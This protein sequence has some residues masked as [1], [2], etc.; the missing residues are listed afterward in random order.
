MTDERDNRSDS[1]GCAEASGSLERLEQLESV[2]D[3]VAD[4]IFVKD[5]EHR[6]VFVNQAFA[7]STGY[8][9]DEMVGK[10]DADL[11]PPEETTIF[12]A[13]DDEVLRN[14]VARD[15][16]LYFT[17]A[18][19]TK[20]LVHT[21]KSRVTLT[22]GQRFVVG[23]MHD[24][25][26]QRSI[27]QT[28]H[29][30]E[31]L[32]EESQRLANL[33][34]WE[35]D[36]EN[37]TLTWSRYLY[38]V[39]GVRPQEFHPFYKGFLAMIHPEDRDRID[40]D[41]QEAIRCG[42]AFSHDY[43]ILRADGRGRTCHGEGRV[44]C[45]E[46][47]HARQMMGIVQDISERYALEQALRESECLMK[48]IVNQV[49]EAITIRN[50]DGRYIFI[51]GQYLSLHGFTDESQVLGRTIEE[52][53]PGQAVA[54]EIHEADER[55]LLTGEPLEQILTYQLPQGGRL[56]TLSTKAPYL[57][58]DGEVLGVIGIGRDI[59]D[60]VILQEQLEQQVAQLEANDRT[61]NE[62]VRS[63]SHELRTPL[64][65]IHGF[66][67]LLEEEAAGPLTNQQ[68]HFVKQIIRGTAR[69]KH[70]VDDL[71]DL[72]RIEAGTFRL[73]PSEGELVAHLSEVA[74][75]MRALAEEAGLSFALQLPGVPLPL[76]FDEQRIA[77]VLINMIGNAIK[78]T[79][80]GGTVTVRVCQN[81]PDAR[82][83][84]TDTGP[85][86]ARHDQEKLFRHYSQLEGGKS[87]GGTGLGLAISKALVEAH[88]GRVGVESEVG[89]G[90]TFWFTLPMTPQAPGEASP[91]ERR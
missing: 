49:R 24:I 6:Y 60:R 72:A 5:V 53:Y 28:Q 42:R 10:L 56:V 14:G 89:R 77:Q 51:N 15:A 88:G 17:D 37:N 45:D 8:P 33:G 83:E 82:V 65:S 55:T 59:T 46:R 64:T 23:T 18:H 30:Y 27:E 44:Q 35:W 81:G 58:P 52:L 78:F 50:R 61:R 47:G 43:R 90:S 41:I 70:L 11:Y 9:R 39:F 69:L 73:Q 76:R 54:R 21:T 13:Q 68:R 40:R 71:L 36:L 3:A 16:E 38:Q 91:S 48:S 34:N 74:E 19:G 29:R 31:A 20:R 80:G 75:S 85:G 4:P 1:T 62:F 7:Q 22:S 26:L 57:S 67:E 2:L 25:T 63:V 66:G 84:V 12:H 87:R 32:L 86:I 79:P